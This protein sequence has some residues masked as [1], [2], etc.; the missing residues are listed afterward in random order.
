MSEERSQERARGARDLDRAEGILMAV[1]G[2]SASEAW[3][4]LL[5]VSSHHRVSVLQL[6][7]ALARLTEGRA[8]DGSASSHAALQEWGPLLAK[9]RAAVGEP[10]WG[11]ALG[12]SAQAR[13]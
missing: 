10:T 7:R 9:P 2:Y 12:R 3:N 4:E 13:R 1:R 6:A 11:S 8:I 5:A